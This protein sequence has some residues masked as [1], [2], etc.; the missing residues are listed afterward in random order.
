M[1]VNCCIIICVLANNLL[2]FWS[3]RF[4]HKVRLCL[5]VRASVR[6]CV[7]CV[8]VCMRGRVVACVS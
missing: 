2:C 3:V 6:A 4:V 8:R 1:G 5:F 7:A